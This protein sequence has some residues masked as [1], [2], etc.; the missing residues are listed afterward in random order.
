MGIL[1][2]KGE[3]SMLK[4]HPKMLR[5]IGLPSN[6][7]HEEVRKRMLAIKKSENLGK[8]IKELEK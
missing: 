3:N 2:M 1:M 6:A 4:I 7:T 5:G 8:R